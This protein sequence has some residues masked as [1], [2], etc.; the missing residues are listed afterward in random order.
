M[1]NINRTHYHELNQLLWDFHAKFIA[2]KMAFEL[3]ERRWAYVD[4]RNLCDEEEKLIEQLTKE[5]GN[6][7]F[8][9]ATF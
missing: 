9:P 4:Q 7:V 1:G 3:Y 5:F 2:P 8:M 6:G